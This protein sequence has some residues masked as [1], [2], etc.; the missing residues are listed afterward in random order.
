MVH[1]RLWY[2]DENFLLPHNILSVALQQKDKKH[3]SRCTLQTE[4]VARI[5][6]LNQVWTVPICAYQAALG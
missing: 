5:C 3:S 1:L 6:L 4:S 2:F